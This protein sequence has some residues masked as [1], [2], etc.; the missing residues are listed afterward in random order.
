MHARPPP[1]PCPVQA[2]QL[3]GET[4]A[5]SAILHSL[6]A[7]LGIQHD[8][9][10]WMRRYVQD[11]RQYMPPQHRRFVASL[12]AGPASL[13]QAAEAQPGALKVCRMKLRLACLPACLPSCNP[14]GFL[15]FS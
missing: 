13:R 9:C 5:Q 10:S 4:G 14:A 8:A 12:E 2:Q 3:Y 1:D 7:A 11:M 15:A 6:D